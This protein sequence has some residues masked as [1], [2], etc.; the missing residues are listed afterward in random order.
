MLIDY[1]TELHYAQTDEHKSANIIRL[2]TIRN[3]TTL[4]RSC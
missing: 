1:H 3:Y 4:K 2:T